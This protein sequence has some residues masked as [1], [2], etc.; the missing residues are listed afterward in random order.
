MTIQTTPYPAYYGPRAAGLLRL[1]AQDYRGAAEEL[2]AELDATE[3]YFT[4]AFE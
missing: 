4:A 1:R 2:R 3:R